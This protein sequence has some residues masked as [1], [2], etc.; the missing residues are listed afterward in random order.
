MPRKVRSSWVPG[1]PQTCS[2]NASFRLKGHVW[3]FSRKGSTILDEVNKIVPVL[4]SEPCSC[5]TSI[6]VS[7]SGNVTYVFPL[8]LSKLIVQYTLE[9]FDSVLTPLY[10]VC[11]L[12]V[13]RTSTGKLK[14][15][16]SLHSGGA[17]AL[18]C[19]GILVVFCC[20]LANRGENQV[21]K[22]FLARH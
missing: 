14:P 19:L 3:I 17:N 15:S 12:F 7:C 4:S 16:S 20:T 1:S 2:D 13:V 6:M 11:S 22:H 21:S 10:T 5:H 18:C 8:A 9:T